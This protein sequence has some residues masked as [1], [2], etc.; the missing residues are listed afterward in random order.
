MNGIYFEK[1]GAYL[2][3][4][5]SSDERKGF[6]LEMA[7]DEEM[8]STYKLYRAVEMEGRNQELNRS[9]ELALKN[10]LQ[11]FQVQ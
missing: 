1:I 9:A 10:T 6:E 7:S 4:E 11:T 8:A 2:N 5:M 3:N